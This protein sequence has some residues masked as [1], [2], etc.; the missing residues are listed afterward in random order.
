MRLSRKWAAL[1]VA[2]P[3][4]LTTIFSF[5][6]AAPVQ[7]A[8]AATYQCVGAP[9]DEPNGGAYPEPR[10]F[11]ES[12]AWWNSDG[13]VVPTDVGHHV[14]TGTCLPIDGQPAV[15][16]AEINVRSLLH[17]QEGMSDRVTIDFE[18]GGPVLS[19]P[20]V[21]GSCENCSGWT[22][23]NVTTT[24][25]WE[26]RIRTNVPDEQLAQSGDQRMFNS[27]GWMVCFGNCT[28]HTGRPTPWTVARGWYDDQPG[29]LFHGYQNI[30]FK[31]ALRTTPLTSPWSVTWTAGPGADGL[32]T[33]YALSTVD[34]DMHNGFIG[35]VESTCSAGCTRT[36]VIDPADYSPGVHRLVMVSSDGKNAGV[37]SI[38]FIVPGTVSPTPTP[39]PTPTPTP[40]P[41]VAPTPTPEPAAETPRPTPSVVGLTETAIASED[42]K[43]SQQY[44]NSNY[45]SA[46]DLRV[47]NTTYDFQSYLKFTL[48]NTN[49][50]YDWAR[51]RLYV[52]DVTGNSVR[53]Y[54][55]SAFSESTL[56]WSNKP[57]IGAAISQPVIP[58]STG[59]VEFDVGN[60]V[61]GPGTYYIAIADGGTNSVFFSSSE[62]ANP[63]QLQVGY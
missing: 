17:D 40:V 2:I 7:E 56:K 34:P 48:T 4:T 15:M 37:E 14:H 60:F 53:A 9:A 36:D 16:P 28:S 27:T 35:Y 13:I 5:S 50:P 63:P 8:K 3:L 39:A 42:A 25:R 10:V 47:L 43:V 57:A 38:A 61:N 24:G 23:F 41:T 32:P 58:G 21:I 45:G 62:G 55:T 31:T 6:P 11:V 19:Q 44:P 51:L 12:Q 29:G 49:A 46:T 59:W 22:S 54:I 30:T 1:A 26:L 33:V 52:T 20:L 18:D